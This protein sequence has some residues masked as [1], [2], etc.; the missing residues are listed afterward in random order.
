VPAKKRDLKRPVPAHPDK[1]GA[2]D[3]GQD[4]S[5]LRGFRAMRKVSRRATAKELDEL[6]RPKE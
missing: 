2:P 3:V 5:D 1:A 4:D 6:I